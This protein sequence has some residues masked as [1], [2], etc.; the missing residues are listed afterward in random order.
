MAQDMVYIAKCPMSFK[1]MYILSLLGGV[2]YN[3][4]FNVVG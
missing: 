4:E 2:F 3:C 1:R